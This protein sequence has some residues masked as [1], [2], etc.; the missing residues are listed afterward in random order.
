MSLNLI[1]SGLFQTRFFMRERVSLTPSPSDRSI[2]AK[3]CTSVELDVNYE[4]VW[5]YG[6][7]TVIMQMNSGKS[8]F[9][10]NP[11][12]TNSIMPIFARNIPVYIS[13]NLKNGLIKIIANIII[14]LF[15]N[16]LYVFLCFFIFGI[17]FLCLL[18]LHF[19]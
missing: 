5:L 12:K 14:L 18:Y 1:L 2:A 10:Y 3:I 9:P 17:F 15:V 6:W 4:N 8:Y 7:D 19:R 11:L 13:N 16:L